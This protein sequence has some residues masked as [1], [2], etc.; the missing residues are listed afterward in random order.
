M[1]V[2]LE[3]VHHGRGDLGANA[4][5]GNQ[6]NRPTLGSLCVVRRALCVCVCVCVCV[7]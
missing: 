4:V 7:V 6:C 5:A 1:C 3:D 2:Y